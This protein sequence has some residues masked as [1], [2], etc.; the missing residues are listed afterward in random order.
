MTIVFAQ[1]SDHLSSLVPSIEW[2]NCATSQREFLLPPPALAQA[3][4]L[5]PI[6]FQLAAA[7]ASAPLWLLFIITVDV[8]PFVCGWPQ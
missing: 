4:M 2:P 6:Q 3:W 5:L 8:V 1:M 7:A